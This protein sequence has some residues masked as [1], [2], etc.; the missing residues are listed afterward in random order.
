MGEKV[1]R[2]VKMGNNELR[3]VRMIGDR[4]CRAEAY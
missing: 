3:E 1:F 2:G 4:G